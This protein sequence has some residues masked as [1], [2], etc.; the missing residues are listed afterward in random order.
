MSSRDLRL[1]SW[2]LNRQ[3]VMVAFDNRKQARA[4]ALP[5]LADGGG[6]LS[7]DRDRVGT[8]ADGVGDKET[9]E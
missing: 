8:R 9:G 5:V 3:A 4:G 1:F 6:G 2:L 7:G